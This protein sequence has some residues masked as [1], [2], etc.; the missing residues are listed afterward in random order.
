MGDV[1]E[2]VT[3]NLDKGTVYADGEKTSLRK[4]LHCSK[5]KEEQYLEKSASGFEKSVEDNSD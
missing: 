2:K 5:K 1:Y 4:V 3:V